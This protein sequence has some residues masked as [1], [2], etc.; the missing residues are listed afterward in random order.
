M[1]EEKERVRKRERGRVGGER[2]VP[3]PS[4][5]Y[6]KHVMLALLYSLSGL[7]CMIVQSIVEAI[8]YY[9]M[10]SD[11]AYSQQKNSEVISSRTAP[12]TH[13][14]YVGDTGN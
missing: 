8:N 1:G 10:Y 14:S 2:V 3:F 4:C 6:T 9:P 7:F 11:S 12:K 13:D 5:E